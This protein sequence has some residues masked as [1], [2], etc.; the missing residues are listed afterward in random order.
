VTHNYYG[1]ALFRRI[2]AGGSE[3]FILCPAKYRIDCLRFWSNECDG[4]QSE[5]VLAA[6]L[7]GDAGSVMAKL[8]TSHRLP[9][10]P[11]RP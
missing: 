6:G 7:K 5:M 8:L 1:V 11:P 10:E 2:S 9:I 3:T 4:L